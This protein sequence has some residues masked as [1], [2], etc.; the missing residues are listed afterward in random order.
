LNEDLLVFNVKSFKEK[1]DHTTAQDYLR[2]GNYLWNSGYFVGSINT[3][4]QAMGA[5][6]PELLANYE[7]LAAAS[8]ENYHAVYLSFK[9]ISIDYALIEKVPNLL[10]IPAAFDWLDLGSFS[11][12]AKVA[13][14]D[15]AG[16][17][18]H[19]D[20]IEVE[21]VQNTYIENHEAK[22]V[23]V[24]GLD[25]C[26]VIN[27]PYGILVTRKDLAQKVGDVSKRLT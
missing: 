19:G 7:Q 17:S 4:K 23:V 25:N 10:V 6:A 27:T 1:P 9:N 11:D 14:S 8:P 2:S 3:F 15:E 12:L 21:E 26:V 16:N 5:N 18:T 20:S 13:T 22:P 24:I